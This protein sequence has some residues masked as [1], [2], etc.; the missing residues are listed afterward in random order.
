MDIKQARELTQKYLEG[1]CS[2]EENA[3]FEGW[4][5]QRMKA[6]PDPIAEPDYEALHLR[7]AESLPAGKPRKYL[8]WPRFAAAASIVFAIGTGIWF[9]NARNSN[10]GTNLSL[11]QHDVAPGKNIATLTLANGKTITLS[12]AKT[13]VVIHADK[14]AY[15]DGSLV[16]PNSS[17][18]TGKDLVVN[19]P[20]GGQYQ[21]ILPDG[22]KVWLNAASS[23]KFPAN[24]AGVNQ[25][26]VVLNGEAYF[27]VH[28]DRK[29][30]F[31]VES[32]GQVVEVL[33]THFNISANPDEGAIKTTLVEGSVKVVQAQTNNIAI[34]KPNQQ[35]TITGGI[36]KIKVDTV[37][38]ES[39]LAWKNGY[40]MFDDEDLESILM[41]VA[42]WYDV[43]IVYE[44][45]PAGLS[46]IGTVSRSR[47]VS[48]VLHALE[49]TGKIKFKIEDK[50]IT[51]L[52]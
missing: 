31:I 50:K 41:K 1:K 32:V 27:E 24:F 6:T 33:G 25:R 14:L 42:K 34:L 45:K 8:L 35:S 37:D 9:Y 40:F 5:N 26:K 46:F 15:N 16:T 18:Q 12:D 3:I 22:T 23:L 10:R 17:G 43:E 48:E 2:P 28:K 11:S 52:R 21:L 4:Y 38:P 39:A 51:V 20:R 47:N 49:R 29:Q 13:G 36:D 30:P 44:Q 19:T 7:L